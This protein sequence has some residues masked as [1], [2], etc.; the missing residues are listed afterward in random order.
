MGVGPNE[1]KPEV[2]IV[3]HLIVPEKLVEERNKGMNPQLDLIMGTLCVGGEG[4]ISSSV[5]IPWTSSRNGHWSVVVSLTAGSGR[6]TN[7][8]RVRPPLTTG[9]PHPQPPPPPTHTHP[10]SFTHTHTPLTLWWRQFPKA[11]FIKL[12]ASE[13]DHSISPSPLPPTSRPPWTTGDH[14]DPDP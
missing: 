9:Q 2:K 10:P 4:I 12:K 1:I 11:S 7:D 14:W 8:H 3:K 13:K 6:E 5:S